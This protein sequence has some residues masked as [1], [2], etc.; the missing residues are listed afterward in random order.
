MSFKRLGGLKLKSNCI[1]L[2]QTPHPL[3]L[4]VIPFSR[5][6][7]YIGYTAAFQNF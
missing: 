6:Y 3:G 2:L 7:I 5:I 4:N 1:N